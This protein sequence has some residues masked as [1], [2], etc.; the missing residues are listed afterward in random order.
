MGLGT[1][2]EKSRRRSPCPPQKRT[3]FIASPSR[4]LFRPEMRRLFSTQLIGQSSR[5]KFDV[6]ITNGLIPGDIPLHAAVFGQAHRQ[7]VAGVAY[8]IIVDRAAA[9]E[10]ADAVEALA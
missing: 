5:G 10:P 7:Q 2:S 4:C 8:G 1:F 6:H 9:R 3:T